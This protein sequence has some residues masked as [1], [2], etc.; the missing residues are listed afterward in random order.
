MD[1]L[2][3]LAD[4]LRARGTRVSDTARPDLDLDDVHRTFD[5]LL[6][7]A[8]SARHGDGS[9]RASPPNSPPC[10]PGPTPSGRG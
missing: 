7:S 1:R 9:A 8:T 6:R 4:F 10:R 5:V 2:Q 3:A